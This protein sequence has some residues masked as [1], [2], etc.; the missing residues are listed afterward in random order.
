MKKKTLKE[1]LP[2]KVTVSVVNTMGNHKKRIVTIAS[3]FG[4]IF[5]QKNRDKE[6]E[7]RL[8]KIMN[9]A[10]NAS[11]LTF[12][13]I[14][15]KLIWNDIENQKCGEELAY[16]KNS[17]IQNNK[18]GICERDAKNYAD[19]FVTVMPTYLFYDNIDNVKEDIVH[20]FESIKFIRGEKSFQHN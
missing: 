8:S 17:I 1:W 5:D 6:L 15:H 2:N 7:I 12:P 19:L 14:Y 16:I 13:L 18:T 11:A 3:L 20:L 9:L 10:D 4:Y